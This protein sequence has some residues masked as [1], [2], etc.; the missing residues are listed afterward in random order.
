MNGIHVCIIILVYDIFAELEEQAMRKNKGKNAAGSDKAESGAFLDE[1][2]LYLKKIRKYPFFSRAEELEHFQALDEKKQ[3]LCNLLQNLKNHL[4]CKAAEER[5]PELNAELRR[6]G[7]EL[8]RAIADKEQAGSA[9]KGQKNISGSFDAACQPEVSDDDIPILRANINLLRSQIRSLKQHIIQSNLSLAVVIAKSYRKI[10]RLPFIDLIQEGNTG[11]MTAVDKFDYRRGNRFS[12][13]AYSWIR[14]AI[15]RSITEQARTIRIPEHVLDARS[16]VNEVSQELEQ[17]LLR[18]PRPEE[19]ADKIGIKMD[20][21]EILLAANISCRSFHGKGQNDE[22]T[23]LT[24]VLSDQFNHFE[25]LE[26]RD[27][28]ENLSRFLKGVLTERE[29][30]VMMENIIAPAAQ[31]KSLEEIAKEF[32]VTKGTTQQDKSKAL[33]KVKRI[34]AGRSVESMDEWRLAM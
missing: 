29:F 24:Q 34:I 9:A 10:C 5:D 12:T 26:V 33:A 7:K 14:S 13:Y 22:G 4:E 6:V 2:D 18:E 32:N 15:S 31:W 20:K 28:C 25:E 21:V 1:L 17:V 27:A 19:I 3:N 30:K 16:A 11:L 8:I 23:D